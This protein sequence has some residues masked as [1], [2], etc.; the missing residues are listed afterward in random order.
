MTGE[1]DI[2]YEEKDFDKGNYW[3]V[4][5]ALEKNGNEKKSKKKMKKKRKKKKKKEKKR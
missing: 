2:K 4:R 5:E 1:R 3:F